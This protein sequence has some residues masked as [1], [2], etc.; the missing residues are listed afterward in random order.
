[1]A[2]H[3]GTDDVTKDE[4]LFG[5]AIIIVTTVVV[6]ALVYMQQGLSIYTLIIPL[7]TVAALFFAY[8]T[9][10]AFLRMVGKELEKGKSEADEDYVKRK[11]LMLVCP[12]CKAKNPSDSTCCFNCGERL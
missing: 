3:F 4:N 11:L 6:M 7:V 12:K 9:F 1:M 8:E 2:K 5:F 10:K